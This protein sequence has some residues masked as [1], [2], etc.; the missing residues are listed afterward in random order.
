[1]IKLKK[2]IKE[3]VKEKF[4]LEYD[5]DDHYVI[6]RSL[7][8]ITGDIKEIESKCKQEIDRMISSIN[9]NSNI[10]LALNF[11]ASA[12][13]AAISESLQT[14]LAQASGEATE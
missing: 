2:L 8:K 10:L 11:M 3:S 4:G 13:S 6:D 14:I 9:F 12:A 1:M 7:E 5:D